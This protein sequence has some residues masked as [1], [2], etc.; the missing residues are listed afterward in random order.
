MT[1]YIFYFFIKK[2]CIKPRYKVFAVFLESRDN[3]L[4][5]FY[6]KIKPLALLNAEQNEYQ[7]VKKYQISFI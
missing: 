2:I 6:I 7:I 1:K 3:G 4:N 5:I